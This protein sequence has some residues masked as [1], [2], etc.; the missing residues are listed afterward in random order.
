MHISL[1]NTNVFQDKRI[2]KG[3]DIILTGAEGTSMDTNAGG[4]RKE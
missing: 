2:K 1:L 3:F 4:L